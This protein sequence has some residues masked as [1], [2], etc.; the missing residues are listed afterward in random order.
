MREAGALQVEARPLL[1]CARHACAPFRSTESHPE[2]D[3]VDLSDH[4]PLV[5]DFERG[6]DDDP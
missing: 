5:V 1:H 2:R 4:C 3:Y 6:R